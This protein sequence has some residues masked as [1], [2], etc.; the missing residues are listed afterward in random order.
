MWNSYCSN[1]D[2]L[3]FFIL[4]SWLVHKSR[5]IF[6]SISKDSKGRFTHQKIR[7]NSL[8]NTAFGL[9]LTWVFLGYR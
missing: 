9:D 6:W 3:F 8:K 4:Q 1:N 5:S 2:M 7:Q